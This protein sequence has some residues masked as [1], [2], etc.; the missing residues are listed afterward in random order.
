MEACMTPLRIAIVGAGVIGRT[1]IAAALA[2]S[3]CRLVGIAEADAAARAA[4]PVG[5]VPRFTDLAPLL[6]AAGAEAVI[7][8]TPNALHVPQ[9]LACIA[10]GLPVL[11]EKPVAD[12]VADAATLAETAARAGVPVLVG[13][14]R[15]HN[16]IIA[17]AR[18]L[19]AG[20][21]L[22]RV[23]TATVLCNLCKPDTYFDVAWR[24]QKGG[25]PVLIN[26]IHEIDLLRHLLGEITS[27]QALTA[28]HGRSLEVED[29]AAVLLR[30][31][32]GTLATVTLSDATPAPWSWDLAAGENPAFRGAPAPSHM[33]AGTGASLSLPD[34]T[35][36]HY[37]GARGWHAELAPQPMAPTHGDPYAAQLRHFVAVA[38]GTAAPLVSAADAT[39]TLA[40]T[41]AVH[42]AAAGG[43]TICPG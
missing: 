21:R 33:F 6:D 39:R 17:R 25:G 13:H 5:D 40:A 28:H 7:L 10:R 22:G 38:R 15:R 42:R 35:L 3:A 18:E 1:H 41:L 23:L 31:A 16:P 34:L 24:R 32:G 19:I 14:H 37:P 29:T 12:S 9:A 43:A 20:G 2:E 8:A 26:L 36:W 27:V 30:F 11:V 4:A